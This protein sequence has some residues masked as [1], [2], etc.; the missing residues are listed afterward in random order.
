M[1]LTATRPTLAPSTDRTAV[2]QALV[3]SITSGHPPETFLWINIHRPDG[4]VNIRYAWT[5]GGTDLGDRID[6]LA[7]AAP[8]DAA[9]WLE[10]TAR[11]AQTSHRG[12]IETQAHPL[13]PI[14]ADVQADV[15][16]PEERRAALHRAL[17]LGA[18]LTGQQRPVRIPRWLGVGPT[19]LAHRTP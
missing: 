10:I 9:D 3:A 13:R 12:R 11:H 1:P 19:L 6:L 14:L 5:D 18:E 8:F 7:L 15:R 17:D 2:E 16:A 4:G